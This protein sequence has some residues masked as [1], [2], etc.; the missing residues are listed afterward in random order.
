MPDDDCTAVPCHDRPID[1]VPHDATE[2]LGPT[3]H[4]LCPRHGAHSG[5]RKRYEWERQ[6]QHYGMWE[7]SDVS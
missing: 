5:R 4:W 3:E 6:R 7:W 2:S 1:Q